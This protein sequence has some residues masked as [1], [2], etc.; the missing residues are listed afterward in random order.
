MSQMES[1]NWAFI[2]L[3]WQFKQDAKSDADSTLS[4]F[5]P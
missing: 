4:H 1:E 2:H 5:P 3:W